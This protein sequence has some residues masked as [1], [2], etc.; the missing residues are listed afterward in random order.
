[1]RR[2]VV[3]PLHVVDPGRVLRGEPIER[4]HEVGLHVGIGILLDGERGRGM[5]QKD[6]QRPLAGAGLREEARGMIGDLGE[7]CAGRI[8]SSVALAISCGRGDFGAGCDNR[9][10][11]VV[12]T[13][14][15]PHAD[16]VC[17]WRS[18]RG[19]NCYP[20]RIMSF[21]RW[22]IISTNRRQAFSN[23]SARALRS[24]C[25]FAAS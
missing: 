4:G 13:R 17:N 20:L 11:R 15:F 5:A 12:A 6:Q 25:N 14:S 1:M 2:H 21:W 7:A 8:Q 18:F 9:L 24:A 23:A 10:E 19:C 22:T 16:P 3:R